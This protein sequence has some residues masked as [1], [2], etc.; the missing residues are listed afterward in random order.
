MVNVEIVAKEL[1][2][3]QRFRVERLDIEECSIGDEG[4]NILAEFASQ[5]PYLKFL[6]ISNNN[7]KFE[8][9]QLFCEWMME[10]ISLIVLFVHWNP[11]GHLGGMALAELL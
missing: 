7:I 11:I 2:E 6:N 10:T 1:I 5:S 8:G 9:M 4:I 3:D